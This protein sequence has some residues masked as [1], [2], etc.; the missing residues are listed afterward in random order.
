VSAG[1]PRYADLPVLIE[2]GEYRHAWD[3]YQDGD[4]LGALGGI[5]PEQR[6][7]ALATVVEGRAVNVSLPLTLP[8]PPM[9]GR[10]R[11]THTV[12][13]PHRN[14]SDDK[15][16][17]FYLQSSSQ[18]DGLRHVRAREFGYFKGYT[19]D[20][21]GTDHLGIQEFAREGIIGRGVLLDLSAAYRAQLAEGR[22]ADELYFGAADLRAAAAAAGIEVQPGDVLCLRTGWMERYLAA[23]PEERAALVSVRLW[24]GLEGSAGVAEQLWDWQVAAVAAD[25]PAV[26]GGPGKA[27]FGSLHRRVLPLLGIVF[28]ELF[29]FEALAAELVRAGRSAFAFVAVPLNLPGGVGSPA[30]A[31]AL[32]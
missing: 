11:F 9:F 27:E 30:N 3:H 14:G 20:F 25:N 17:G 6:R 2:E 31:V 16:D 24:P 26:E 19:G 5:G 12:F 23:D 8:D 1:R 18:W 7:A 21:A 13:Q 10:E 15:L 29:D 22:T 28:G 32:L 4:Q